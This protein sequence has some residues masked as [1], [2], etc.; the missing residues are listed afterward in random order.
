MSVR[1]FSHGQSNPTYLI[2]LDGE[3]V[4]LRKKPPPPILPSAHAIDR[5]YRV[6]E[7]LSST[8]FPVPRPVVFSHD[9]SIIGTEFYIMEYVDGTIYENPR[10][11]DISPAK[12]RKIYIQMANVLAS[13][14]SIPP[15]SIGLATFGR[16][17]GYNGRQLKRWYLQFEKSKTSCPP[18]IVEKM[19]SLHRKLSLRLSDM[20][21]SDQSFTST[22]SSIVHGD[23][24]LDNLI[25]HPATFQILAVLDW[26]L[27]TL[28]DPFLDLAYSCL[29]YYLEE[30]ILPSLALPSPLPDGIPTEEEY[31]RSYCIARGIEYPITVDW[32][33]YVS[34]SLFRLASILAGV[35]HRLH[36]GN[37]SSSD[38]AAVAS[39]TAINSILDTALDVIEDKWTTQRTGVKRDATIREEQ[40]SSIDLLLSKL[41]SFL[42]SHVL[43]AEK[44]LNLH[45]QSEKCWTIHSLQEHLKESA[46]SHGLWNLWITPEL[47][48]LL[49]P[50]LELYCD[51][52]ERKLLT[53]PGL[54]HEQYARCAEVMGFSPWASE[55]FN[56]SAPDTGNME[57]LTRFGT[58]RQQETWL[59]PLLR[60]K[61]R[62]CFAMTEK[63]V[64]SS[65]ATNIESQIN[66]DT[67]ESREYILNGHKWWISGACDPRCAF[68]IFMGKTDASA[69]MHRQ[70]SMIIVPMPHEGIK[71]I[72]PLPVF[73]FM[74]APHGH[75]EMIFSNV[76]VPSEN[77]ILGPGR[78][79]EI[80]QARLGVGRLHHCMRLI[81]MGNRALQL[82][83]ER[84]KSRHSFGKR[85][86][87]HQTIRFDIAQSRIELDAARLVVL[88][89]AKS[90]DEMGNKAARG[91]VSAAKILAPRTVLSIVDRVIQIFGGAGVSDEF[92]LASIW[93]AAR[94]LRIADGPDAVHFETIAK[95]E[96]RKAKL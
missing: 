83:L 1:K 11:Q 68:A 75:A 44:I 48:S 41:A 82:C 12:R 87:D 85:Y 16:P 30:D 89:A 70:Q 64:A 5:E 29:P 24:R 22:T 91:K 79:F 66:K 19:D 84:V 95:I 18:Y 15:E 59:L 69:E 33:F 46:K 32:D 39:D 4:V 55:I 47:Q 49:A 2:T 25:F 43:P 3:R 60:G 74:D 67:S 73:G 42:E 20:R 62:S 17:A 10:L 14:H 77:I 34:L 50:L 94:T 63:K 36:Q 38:A 27:S 90:L 61:I 7:S 76:R 88:D 71:S 45:A 65:D 72:K 35:K 81:G 92:P 13:L 6:I 9:A 21:V 56:C 93:A 40:P 86:D 37:A 54:S 52:E 8:G 23:Y 57:V 78:G 53:G 26:E 96:L 31:L 51:P 80:A 58:L 28:G